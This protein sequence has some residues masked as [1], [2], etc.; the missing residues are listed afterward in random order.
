MKQKLFIHVGAPKCGSSALQS[1][2][3]ILQKDDELKVYNIIYPLEKSIGLGRGNA[4]FLF[5]DIMEN[6]NFNAT[7]EYLRNF[8][9]EKIFLSF[10]KL[11]GVIAPAL[12]ELIDMLNKQYDITILVAV[13]E[14]SS[15]LLSDFSQYIKQ[16]ISN[17]DFI[18]HVIKRENVIEWHKYIKV[19]RQQNKNF[20]IVVADYKQLFTCVEE[21]L[22]LPKNLLW[23]TNDKNKNSM[24]ANLSLKADQLEVH[25]IANHLDLTKEEIKSLQMILSYDIKVLHH[26]LLEY[27]KRKYEDEYQKIRKI[28]NVYFYKN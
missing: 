16:G 26:S 23:N 22:G 11:Y 20:N 4:E 24:N 18:D 25:R 14:A 1:V 7:L 10:E 2:L 8:K 5:D 13:R 15:W 17:H 19:L 9:S 28:N 6:K 12:N 21:I 27:I 3:E